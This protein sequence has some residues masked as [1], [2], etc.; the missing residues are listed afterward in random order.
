MKDKHGREIQ[1][2]SL[3]QVDDNGKTQLATVQVLQENSCIAWNGSKF[4]PVKDPDKVEI[5]GTV[6]PL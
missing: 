2:D 6:K 1:N 5:K 3:L 4:I